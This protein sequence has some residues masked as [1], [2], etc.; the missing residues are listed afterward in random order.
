MYVPFLAY[1]NAFLQ[2]PVTVKFTSQPIFLKPRAYAL[3]LSNSNFVFSFKVYDIWD[4]GTKGKSLSFCWL[5]YCHLLGTI[6][7]SILSSSSA[8]PSIHP[9]WWWSGMVVEVVVVVIMVVRVKHS[10][11]LPIVSLLPHFH[12]IRHGHH[13]NCHQRCIH[14]LIIIFSNCPIPLFFQLPNIFLLV[15]ASTVQLAPSIA[16]SF[17]AAFLIMMTICN[18]YNDDDDADADADN[19][20]DYAN[21][22]LV[23][24]ATAVLHFKSLLNQQVQQGVSNSPHVSLGTL[25]GCRRLPWWAARLLHST[26]TPEADDAW[27]LAQHIPLLHTCT[28]QAPWT[29]ECTQEAPWWSVQLVQIL[30]TPACQHICTLFKFD[31]SSW[32]KAWQQGTVFLNQLDSIA[33]S[34]FVDILVEFNK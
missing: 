8:S 22:A 28:V 34:L 2:H 27:A 5:F 3:N 30:S 26:S 32:A 31:S 21:D 14:Q 11:W 6:L 1:L 19:D 4:P 13:H 7:T 12:Y 15:D 10:L 16:S 29:N 24:M 9:R 25:L 20:D 23:M 18:C 17:P 33:V